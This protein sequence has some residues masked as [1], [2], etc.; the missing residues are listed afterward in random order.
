MTPRRDRFRAVRALRHPLWWSAVATLALNDHVLK[1]AGVLPDAVTGKLSDAAG[2]LVA[3]VLLAVLTRA[4][5]WRALAFCHLAPLVALALIKLS[6]AIASG[7]VAA[8]ALVGESWAIVADP[9]DL[10]VAIPA[11]AAS[12]WWL[13]RP[14]FVA[15]D[16]ART[17]PEPD[18]SRRLGPR[19]LVLVGLAALACGATSRAPEPAVAAPPPVAATPP[20]TSPGPFA[21]P[22]SASDR[23]LVV[24][25]PAG[26]ASA[27]PSAS[28]AAPPPAPPA[29]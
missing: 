20:K 11:A 21:E 15:L 25:G 1:G 22:P 10:L 12:W 16:A 8:A 17:R 27:S 7:V 9:T 2:L 18:A 4:R 5:R 13:A 23:V 19:E 29:R 26:S 24:A 14:W 6:P 28:V 3:P